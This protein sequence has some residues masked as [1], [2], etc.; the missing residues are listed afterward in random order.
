MVLEK[1]IR[2]LNQTL[3]ATRIERSKT[4]EAHQSRIK[5]LQEKFLED[6][7]NASQDAVSLYCL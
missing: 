6:L 3:G 4:I 7:K 5:Q 2:E 1:T